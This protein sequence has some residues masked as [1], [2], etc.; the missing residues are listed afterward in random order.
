V[1][2][3]LLAAANNLF[4]DLAYPL[5]S[6]GHADSLARL[7][8][9]TLVEA[10][11]AYVATSLAARLARALL[12]TLPVRA[13]AFT[14]PLTV[15]RLRGLALLTLYLLYFLN[16][17]ATDLSRR[18]LVALDAGIALVGFALA[19]AWARRVGEPKRPLAATRSRAL[20]AVVLGLPAA[21]AALHFGFHPS[22]PA[23]PSD[24][25]TG[26]AASPGPAPD[27]RG[28]N[29]LL[30]VVDT[31]RADR[32]SFFGYERETTP[33][34]D[35]LARRGVVFAQARANATRTSPSMASLLTGTS[36]LVHGIVESRTRLPEGL[37]TLAEALRDSGYDTRAVLGNV[38]LGQA[39]GFARGLDRVDEAFR[40]S[41]IDAEAIVD[42]AIDQLPANDARPWFLWVQLM[43]PH[44][45]Y[46]AP[47]SHLERFREDRTWREGPDQPLLGPD[48]RSLVAHHARV[49]GAKSLADYVAAYD[50]GVRFADEQIGR[51]LAAVEALAGERRTLIVVTSDHGESLGERGR[52]FVHGLD[53]YE[54]VARVPLLF[55]HPDL[56]PRV[57][58]SPVRLM[59]VAPTVLAA[60]AG[61]QARIGD[62]RDLLAAAGE[63]DPPRPETILVAGTPRFRTLAITD[64]A[65]KL[66]LIPRPWREGDR[67]AAWKLSVWPGPH[68][69]Q[70]LRHRSYRT[71]LYDLTT[72][73]HE[74]IDR[75][76]DA[77]ADEQR[78]LAALLAAIDRSPGR[79]VDPLDVRDLSENE[80]LELK[81]LGYL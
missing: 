81:A 47:A 28:A 55:S 11:V 40:G 45:P 35:A 67:L 37:P 80:V 56:E 9:L 32:L 74:T 44:A 31:L 73:P 12:G 65:W 36:P 57:D 51:L 53:A 14:G 79:L 63:G 22:P 54:D 30:L 72:D 76:A 21:A 33:V 50:A 13:A 23:A 64:G 16:T 77:E 52:Y 78:L 5:A 75:S 71:E 60:V 26:R 59:D 70:P 6:A 42:R 24:A 43:D 20:R 39:F 10:T 48:G 69:E 34:L 17:F 29:V 66:H 2:A 7:L 61:P 18:T 3:L 4:L 19:I 41:R 46:R 62:G 58:G 15:E 38:N 1:L 68:R 8:V 27:L 25:P 49:R